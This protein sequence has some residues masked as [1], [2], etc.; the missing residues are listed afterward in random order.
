[1]P[2]D[3]RVVPV[4]GTRFKNTDRLVDPEMLLLLPGKYLNF[5]SSVLTH[6]TLVQ[7][8]TNIDASS[9]ILFC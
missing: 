7:V 6:L 9:L 8:L 3:N 2:Y 1:M 4:L 5:L